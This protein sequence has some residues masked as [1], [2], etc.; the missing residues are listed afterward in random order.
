[1]IGGLVGGPVVG[2]GAGLMGGLHRL[3][4]VGGE[5]TVSCSLATMLSGL[6]GS[7]IWYLAGKKFAGV[8]VAVAFATL[9]E[10]LHMG[11]TL[12]I[13]SPYPYA[14]A[15]VERVGPPM[16]MVNAIGMLIFAYIINN[17]IM[18]RSTKEERDRFHDTLEK[19]KFELE[20]A[21]GIQQSFLPKKGPSVD[22]FDLFALN[23]PAKEVGGDFY[24]F[25]DLGDGRSGLVIADVQE[26]GFL[27]RSTWPCP[28]LCSGRPPPRPPVPLE[29]WP[30][31]TA[32]SPRPRNRAC[33]LPCSMRSSTTP[34]AA[35][36]MPMPD[37]TLLCF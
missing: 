11:L 2:I 1:M 24:D 14:A 5:T 16:I 21:K 32:L 37:T 29:R 17:L 13:V 4:F 10:A 7:L 34:A 22:G 36:P 23:V 31:P 35:S 6:F 26:K 25:I 12:M 27:A 3:I 28:A 15:V 9:Q 20:I 30:M 18:E 19:E 33:S 8:L